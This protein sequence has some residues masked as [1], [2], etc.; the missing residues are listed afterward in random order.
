VLFGNDGGQATQGVW[1][2]FWR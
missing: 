2:M 1:W